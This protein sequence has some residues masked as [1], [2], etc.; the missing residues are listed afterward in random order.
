MEKFIHSI[1][2]KNKN[3]K[4]SFNLPSFKDNLNEEQFN[5][6]NNIE[7]PMIVIAG[8]GSGKTRTIIYSV[9]KLIQQGIKPSEIML[10]TFTNK[11]AKEMLKRVENLLGK[12]PQ[13]IW[14]GLFIL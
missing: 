5:V 9:A 8:A 11:A 10:V 7:G 14:G 1:D 6:I 13:G 4:S 12:P 2:E 3:L